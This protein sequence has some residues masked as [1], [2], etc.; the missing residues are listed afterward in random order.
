MTGFSGNPTRACDDYG[1]WQAVSNPCVP[2][3]PPCPLSLDFQNANWAQTE[4]NT[5]AT[6]TCRLGFANGPNGPPTRLCIAFPNNYTTV[7]DS[8]VQNTC[9]IGTCARARAPGCGRVVVTGRTW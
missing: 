4:A 1:V 3:L 6:G 2:V 9:I 5:T 8:T 7:W